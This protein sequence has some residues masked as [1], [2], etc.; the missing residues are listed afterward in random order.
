MKKFLTAA[1]SL[2]LSVSAVFAFAAC[3][4]SGGTGG[5]GGADTPYTSGDPS[6]DTLLVYFSWSGNTREMAEY[7]AAQTGAYV[8]EIVPEV[9]YSDNYNDVAYGRAQEEAE[10]NARPAVAQATYDLIDMERYDTV[11]I[12]FPIWWHWHLARTL[13]MDDGG[14]HLPVFP[15]RFE[16]QSRVLRQLDELCARKRCGRKRARRAVL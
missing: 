9:P 4:T 12:G 10:Q 5:A 16:Q 13:Y 3:E 15:G 1:L 7:I 14:Q 8:V 6:G 2:L 11:L